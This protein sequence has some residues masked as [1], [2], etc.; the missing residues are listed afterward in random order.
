MIR[1]QLEIVPIAGALG[2]EIR[3]INLAQID[4]RRIPSLPLL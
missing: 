2:A 1:T 4:Q 3:G